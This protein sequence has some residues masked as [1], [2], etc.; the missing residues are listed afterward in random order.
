MRRSAY[1]GSWALAYRWPWRSVALPLPLGLQGLQ[2]LEDRN[3]LAVADLHDRLLPRA[4]ATLDVAAA[5]GLGL[6]AQRPHLDHVYLEQRLHRLANLRLVRVEMD[7]EGIPARRREH[8]TLL[9]H[10][11]PQDHL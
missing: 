3:T 1:R 11:R 4:R 9:G 2:A 8:I 5:L 10:H 6:H 7:S